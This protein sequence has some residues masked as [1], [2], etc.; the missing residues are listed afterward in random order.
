LLDV[1]LLGKKDVAKAT[2]NPY[3]NKLLEDSLLQIL[4]PNRVKAAFENEDSRES[5]LFHLFFTSGA[6]DANFHAFGTSSS[7]RWGT[8]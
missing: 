7:P 4:Q 5:S 6:M 8:L 3:V 2:R 1:F